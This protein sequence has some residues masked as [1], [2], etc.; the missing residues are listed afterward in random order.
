M[1]CVFLQGEHLKNTAGHYLTV[2]L[3]TWN[4]VLYTVV[5][6]AARNCIDE[7]SRTAVGPQ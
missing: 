4:G 2:T 6:Q 1:N 7:C 3:E 5:Q